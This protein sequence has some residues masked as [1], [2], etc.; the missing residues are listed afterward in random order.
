MVTQYWRQGNLIYALDDSFTLHW[1]LVNDIYRFLIEK[2]MLKFNL[3]NDQDWIN[4]DI[5]FE[6]WIAEPDLA[7]P[8]ISCYLHQINKTK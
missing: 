3:G 8:D 1:H 2:G 7:K 4:K 6:E 5:T